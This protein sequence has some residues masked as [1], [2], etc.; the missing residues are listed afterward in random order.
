MANA[1]NAELG[2][3]FTLHMA[4]QYTIPD[5]A[6]LASLGQRHGFGRIWINENFGYR[7]TLVALSAIA[8]V[9]E[10]DGLP[11]GVAITHPYARNPLDAAAAFASLTEV[12]ARQN[13]IVGLAIGDYFILGNSVHMLRPSQLVVEMARLLKELWKGETVRFADFPNISS[14]YRLKQDRSFKMSFKPCN[15]ISLYCA[16]SVKL[17]SEALPYCDG[18]IIG[19]EFITLVEGGMLETHLEAIEQSRKRVTE[20]KPFKKMC[21]INVSVSRDRKAARQF[22]SKYVCHGISRQPDALLQRLGIDIKQVEAVRAAFARGGTIHQV[23]EL[24]TDDMIDAIFVAG[25][26]EEC[27]DRVAL[28]LKEAANRGFD[29][30]LMAKLG[31][32]YAEAI[33]ILGDE[34]LPSI[35]RM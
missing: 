22:A 14:L 27:I 33:K 21:E 4:T 26:P 24:V 11:L 23:S 1:F 18:I 3:H 16:G 31:P 32:D 12:M 30:V 28:Y 9:R 20:V 8:A 5:L 6:R 29:H 10:A 17:V 7:H 15:A 2:L 19:G 25:T 34:M 13:L 35:A